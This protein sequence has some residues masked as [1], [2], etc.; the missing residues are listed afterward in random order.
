[1]RII[2]GSARGRKLAEFAGS[3][4]RPTSDRAREAIFS[5]LISR[6][7]SLNDL[8]VLELFAG[9]GAMSLEAL[10]RGAQRAILVDSS[11]QSA[12]L[13]SDNIARCKMEPF[14]ELINRP[15]LSALPQTAKKG[16][17]DLI[18]MDPPYGQ[19]MI[20]QVLSQIKTLQL[21]RQN[22]II[23]AETASDEQFEIPDSLEL[24]EI[25]TYGKSKVHLIGNRPTDDK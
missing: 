19:G 4:I 2:S 3:W 15:V 23:C 10:S 6:Y 20:P 14:A 1:M 12:K 7:D 24:I 21:L 5:I 11:P 8:R 18:F 22:G 9:T 16:P 17:Y 13:I 25:R